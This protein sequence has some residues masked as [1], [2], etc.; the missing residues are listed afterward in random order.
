MSQPLEELKK[1]RLQKLEKI[2]KLGVDPYPAR[3]RRDQTIAQALEMMGKKVAV[4]GRIL[5]I[6]SHGGIQF[7]DLRDQSGKIQL[8]F[9]P[10]QFLGAQRQLL[11]LLDSGDF[12]EATGKVFK[13]NA[14]EIS[15]EVEKF[16]LLTKSVL[17]LP[18]RWYGLKGSED[19]YR[20]RYLDLI[21]NPQ[22]KKIFEIRFKLTQAMREFLLDRGYFEVETPIM[23]TL[24]GGGLARPFK[25]YHNVL[26]IPL[27][28][29]ISTELYLKRLIVGGFEK[30]FEIAKVFRNEGIDKNHYPEFTLLE[31]MEAYIDYK[32]NMELV[33]QM[34]EFA[35]KKAIGATKVIYD[36]K[37]IDFKTPWKRLTMVEAVKQTTG[38]DFQK[39]KKLDEAIKEAKRLGVQLDNYLKSAIGLILAAVFEEKVEKNLIQPTIIYDFPWETSPLAKRCPDDPRFVERWEHFVVGVEA[40]NNYSEL[41]DPVELAARFTSERKKE[42]LGDEETH[43]TDED[44]IEAM[45]YGMPPTSGIGPGIDRLSLVVCQHLGAQNLRDVILFP[46]MKP[47]GSYVDDGVRGD[48]LAKVSTKVDVPVELPLPKNLGIDRKKA[49]D[50]LKKYL[51]V[52]EELKHLYFSEQAMIFYAHKFGGNQ[53]AWGLAGLLHDLD[54]DLVEEDM[55]R[56]GRVGAEIL[57][58]EG[59]CQ[60]IIYCVLAHNERQ[61]WERKTL[62]DRALWASEGLTGL[63]SAIVKLRPDKDINLVTADSVLK[64]LKDTKFASS[65]DREP[66]IKGAE[67]LGL[68]LQEHVENVLQAM[69]G[70]TII[71][72]GVGSKKSGSE[73]IF[74]V[75]NEIKQKFP[76]LKIGMAVVEGVEVHH[77]SKEL[78]KYKR[79]TLTKFSK[80]SLAEVEKISTVKAYREIYRA[81]GAD[82]HSRRPS[83]EALYRRVIQGKGLYNVNTLVDAYNLAVLETKISLGAFDYQK[84]SFPVLLRLAKENEGIILL[85]ENKQTKIEIGEMVYADQSRIMTL[86]VNYR[87]C[88]CT[89]VTTETKNIVLFADG[90]SGISTDEVMDGLDKGI[91]LITRFCGGKLI[92]KFIVE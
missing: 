32:K 77:G 8:V 67:E 64:K 56:H 85:G 54:W 35:V 43:K 66:I 38:V 27:Y 29:R 2:R 89:K 72:E 68:S 11:L 26:G 39:I 58:K 81:F 47:E 55:E 51:K 59:V 84:I 10:S 62:M 88:D 57:E 33:E 21:T 45:E 52:D 36:G 80:M 50:L 14:G 46:T 69:K 12:A 71:Q 28:M 22:S 16:N 79:E 4:V 25:T 1:I 53:E 30:V 48:K 41:N 75:D 15:V 13:T 65:L 3:C 42:K 63:I 37:E 76:G 34:I 5:A 6:R 31:T 49:V 83:V 23:Q 91:E 24:Y 74:Y 73:E 82:W 61:G 7:F 19:K 17:P 9:R 90:C 70:K 18:S 20:K 78:E 92:K 60:P 40:S 86:D 44:F 87:D